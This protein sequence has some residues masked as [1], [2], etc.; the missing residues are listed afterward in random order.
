MVI[1]VKLFLY[2]SFY[3]QSVRYVQLL[4]LVA[5]PNVSTFTKLIFYTVTSNQG[6]FFTFYLYST[7]KRVGV[8]IPKIYMNH[9]MASIFGNSMTQRKL[10]LISA[11]YF[12][13]PNPRI[14]SVQCGGKPKECRAKNWKI[15]LYTPGLTYENSLNPKAPRIDFVRL[16]QQ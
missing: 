4:S 1:G 3:L 16:F 8:V 7:D 2:S 15:H 11:D 10:N 14:D 12:C 13:K 6:C 5:I 9:Q